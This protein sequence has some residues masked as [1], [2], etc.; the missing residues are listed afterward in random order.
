MVALAASAVIGGA[1]L[2]PSNSH[3][4]GSASLSV[5][6]NHDLLDGQTVMLS[7]SGFRPSAS[8][9]VIEC[10]SMSTAAS[11]DQSGVKLSSTA[12]DGSFHNLEFVVHTGAIGDGTCDASASCLIA[13][14]TDPTGSD[15]SQTATAA[16]SFAI[17]RP[18]KTVARSS[19]TSVTTGQKLTITGTVTSKDNSAFQPTMALYDKRGTKHDRVGSKA[20]LVARVTAHSDGRF[21]FQVHGLKSAA[22]YIVEMPQ[23]KRPA[24]VYLLSYSKVLTVHHVRR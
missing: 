7:G 6:P 23:T 18:T 20:T 21:R 19:E 9:I 8:V 15:P 13:A 12:G 1:A 5:T 16:I 10:T 2:S 14:T 4:A 11:C 17:T 22:H 3:A 24:A